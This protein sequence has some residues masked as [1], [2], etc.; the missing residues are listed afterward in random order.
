MA[1]RPQKRECEGGRRGLL[2]KVGSCI[3][4]CVVGEWVVGDEL[5]PERRAFLSRLPREEKET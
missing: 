2:L 5:K 4:V 1:L 3:L